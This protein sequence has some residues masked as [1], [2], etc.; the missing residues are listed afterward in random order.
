LATDNELF[1]MLV[2]WIEAEMALKSIP[3]SVEKNYQATIQPVDVDTANG[4]GA[5]LFLHKL[6]DHRYGSKKIDDI[7]DSGTGLYNE[8]TIQQY[9]TAFQGSTL[10]RQNPADVTSLTASDVLNEVAEILQSPQ[11]QDHF[12]KNY[13]VGIERVIDLPST[14]IVDDSDQFEE[15][16]N[17]EFTL[18]H[19]RVTIRQVPAL[20]TFEAHTY[21]V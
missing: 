17:M 9:E 14:Y 16:P 10:V 19:K 7:Y 11:T 21:P 4:Q 5:Q 3:L 15:S 13:E 8:G 2:G 12:W 1:A 18:T 20:D 6:R